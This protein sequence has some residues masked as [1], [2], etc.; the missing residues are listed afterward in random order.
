MDH[1]LRAVAATSWHRYALEA[2]VVGTMCEILQA[3]LPESAEQCCEI[4]TSDPWVS[5]I[6]KF[7]RKTLEVFVDVKISAALLDV[8]HLKEDNAST[9]FHSP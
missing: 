1:Y 9:I 5:T 7:R 6:V 3:G 8:E 4:R 2:A